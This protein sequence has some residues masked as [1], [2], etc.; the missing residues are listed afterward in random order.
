MIELSGPDQLTIDLY[1]RV[2]HGCERVSLQPMALERVERF[3]MLF[4]RH[5]ET[6]VLCYGVNTG[7]GAMAGIALDEDAR[8][9][10]PRHILLGRAAGTGPPFSQAVVRGAMLIKL[11][12]LLAGPSAVS[13]DLCRY[14][15][16]RL[17]DGFIPHVP[18]EGLGMA[19]E[20]IPLSHLSQTL[21]GEGFVLDEGGRRP[22]GDWLKAHGVEPYVPKSKEG[23]SLINGVAVAP[24]LALEAAQRLRGVLSLM[25]LAA[26]ASVEGL[27]APVE[28]Y[29]A[30][31]GDLR[32]EDGLKDIS[33]VLLSL[34]ANSFVTRRERQPPIS[35]RVIPQVHGVLLHA[36]RRLENAIV[37]EWRSIGDNPAFIADETSLAFGRLVHS[38]NFHC[39]SLTAEV[40]ATTLAVMQVSLLSERRLHRLLDPHQSGLTPQLAL[41]PGLD[42]G[43]V[44]LH[45]AVLGLN[46]KLRS[47]AVPPSLQHGES[48]LGQEDMMTMV[49]PALDR[50]NEVERIVG[51]VAVHEL[52]TAL[53]AIDQRGEEPGTGIAAVRDRVR[54]DIPAYAGDR[55]YGP[56]LE[57]LIALVESGALGL[58]E[59]P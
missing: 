8:A 13:A 54:Q 46:A 6:G 59:V 32:P 20:I 37:S 34:L 40:E 45:K 3:R 49:F 47:L 23:L 16:D 18:S 30:D 38:G 24:A 50:L 7:L 19:G 11:V 2:V 42:A 22:A 41:Q 25:T 39:A 52:Y 55:S 1:N 15:A 14:L 17:N 56:D 36:I 5:L 53:A 12:Q 43:L 28:A 35:C 44:I 57:H 9:K 48:S 4:L 26:A 31:I 10:L 33:V 27:G 51:R 29:S 21:A 58:P